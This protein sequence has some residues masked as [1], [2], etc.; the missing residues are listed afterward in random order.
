LRQIDNALLSEDAQKGLRSF[1]LCG[2][3]G[4]GKTEIAIEYLHSRKES[5]QAIFWVSADTPEKLAAGYSE[6]ARALGLEEADGNNDSVATRKK[7]KNWMANPIIRKTGDI[8]S[9]TQKASWLLILDNADGPEILDDYWPVNGIGSVL[10]TS[11]NPIAKEGLYGRKS[12][13]V[14]PL[15]DDDAISLLLKLTSHEKDKN[16]L[17]LSKKIVQTLG[18]LPLAIVQMSAIIRYGHHTLQD[19]LESY[20][21]DAKKLQETMIPGLTYGQTVASVWALEKLP[22]PAVAL[23]RVLSLLDPDGIPEAILFEGADKVDLDGYPQTKSAYF[24]ARDKLIQ[25]SL[26]TRNSDIDEIRIHRLVQDVVRQKM[27]PTDLQAVFNPVIVLL[28]AVWSFVRLDNRN[29]VTRR[30]I[31]E[32]YYPQIARLKCL[33]E[34]T[35]LSGE[36][37]PCIETAALFNEAAW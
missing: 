14:S 6:I 12:V 5:F 36:L 34:K 4:I 16:S 2:L 19:F 28:S 15:L 17:Q 32:T 9:P 25:S 23:L 33:F 21:E 29:L 8:D 10:A 7:V 22:A 13:D 37:K 35:L 31:C 18:G 30:R 1:I 20:E 27:G 24:D 11:R 26:I 3:G